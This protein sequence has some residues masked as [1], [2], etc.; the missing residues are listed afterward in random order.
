MQTLYKTAI[1]IAFGALVAAPT[2]GQDFH[3][4]QVNNTVTFY[5]PAEAGA[6]NGDHRAS[7]HYR[8]QWGS[9]ATPYVSYGVSYDA[10]LFKKDWDHGFLGAGFTAFSDKAGENQIGMAGAGLSVAYH[11]EMDESNFLSA[12]LH[13]GFAQ[14]S[15]TPGNAQWDNQYDGFSGYDGTLTTGELWSFESVAVPDISAGILWSFSTGDGTL[16]SNDGLNIEAGAS[17]AHITQPN[18]SLYGN[19]DDRYTRIIGHFNGQIGVKNTPIGF[20]PSIFYARQGTASELLI[21]SG[22]RYIV[23]EG[24]RYT[25]NIKET[26]I[27]VGGYLRRKD[28]FIGALTIEYANWALAFSYD[29][30]TSDLKTVSNGNGGAEITLRFTNPNPFKGGAQ[31]SKFF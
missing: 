5:N 10:S 16:S 26:A 30:N 3:F 2:K 11:L 25:G 13:A 23:V 20:T 14:M 17:V 1:A 22:I 15:M 28:A 24:S 21:G 9:V 12:G 31:H 27:T 29:F 18:L 6:F 4:S 8:S 7:I 19:E